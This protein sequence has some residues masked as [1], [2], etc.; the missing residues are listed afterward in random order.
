MPKRAGIIVHEMKAYET[1]WY[2]Y[3]YKPGAANIISKHHEYKTSLIIMNKKLTKSTKIDPHKINKYTL[4]YKLL[5]H[6]NKTQT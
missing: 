5:Q 1:S 3:I 2:S 4:Q 6:N